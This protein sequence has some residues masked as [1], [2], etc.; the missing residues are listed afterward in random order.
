MT[1]EAVSSLPPAQPQATPLPQVL[2]MHL[3]QSLER[4][5]WLRPEC[6][7]LS[8]VPYLRPG[9]WEHSPHLSPHTAH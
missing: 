9:S 4:G 6:L 8:L 3:R 2:P 7:R 1:C 5:R